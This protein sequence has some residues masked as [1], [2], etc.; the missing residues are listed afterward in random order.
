M[1]ESRTVVT[2]RGYYWRVI[3]SELHPHHHRSSKTVNLIPGA[4]FIAD[5]ISYSMGVD[6]LFLYFI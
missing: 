4:I 5:E 1:T 2:R 6:D 3:V